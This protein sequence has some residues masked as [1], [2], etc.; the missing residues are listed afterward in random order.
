MQ[1]LEQE[2]DALKVQLQV[3][4]TELAVS[5]ALRKQ[6]ETMYDKE[7]TLQ[8]VLEL[9][10]VRSTQRKAARDQASTEDLFLLS[11]QAR[12]TGPRALQRICSTSSCLIGTHTNLHFG[13]DMGWTSS[14][15]SQLPGIQMGRA[16]LYAH[17]NSKH[18]PECSTP[19]GPSTDAEPHQTTFT[20]SPHAGSAMGTNAWLCRGWW[21]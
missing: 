12:G 4:Q 7:R 5:E 2:R 6:Q 19:A 11:C 1:Q 21:S 14:S 10:R 20:A 15:C 16:R 3:V 13:K 8:H 17:S 9:E 18:L